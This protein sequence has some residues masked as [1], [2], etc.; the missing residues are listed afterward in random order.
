MDSTVAQGG[1]D[2]PEDVVGG[3][4]EVLKMSWN[5]STRVL[6]HITDA[7]CHGTSYHSM[8]D[9]FPQG[10]P[11]GVSP[12]SLVEKLIKNRTHYY[13]VE[14]SNYSQ[15]MTDIFKKVYDNNQ[16]YK[17]EVKRLQDNTSDL[18][19]SVLESIRDSL[20]YTKRNYV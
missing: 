1:G 19:P 16:Q 3:M 5:A 10:D 14:I 20:E 15:Q 4:N 11:S 18:L 7:P 13:F 9:D 12:E 17:F 8:H 6:I 2:G